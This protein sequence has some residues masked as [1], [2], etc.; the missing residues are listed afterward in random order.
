MP[1][2]RPFSFLSH[3][4][5]LVTAHNPCYALTAAVEDLGEVLQSPPTPV[6]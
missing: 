4:S 1:L 5:L 3:P 6:S 2:P